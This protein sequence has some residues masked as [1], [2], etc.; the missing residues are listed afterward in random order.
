MVRLPYYP[1]LPHRAKHPLVFRHYLLMPS[2]GRG[3][4]ER[5]VEGGHL[6]AAVKICQLANE[7]S[8]F[9]SNFQNKQQKKSEL[10]SGKWEEDT[11][12]QKCFRKHRKTQK[13]TQILRCVHT[14][15]RTER[16]GPQTDKTGKLSLLL[17]LFFSQLP[18]IKRELGDLL[19]RVSRWQKNW[20][21][22]VVP[23][24]T[25]YLT[26]SK[27]PVMNLGHSLSNCKAGVSILTFH[28]SW[29][30]FKWGF[31]RTMLFWE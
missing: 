17:R 21:L 31:Q 22:L 6:P 27:P 7:A 3:W 15:T 1:N 2:P 14:H 23:L 28:E 16:Q 4:E 12:W 30:V 9:V 8:W 10:P 25:H 29:S 26:S 19:Q 20:I 18:N 24:L 11:T 13:H 5:V